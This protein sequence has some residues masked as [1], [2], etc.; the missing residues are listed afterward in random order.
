MKDFVKNLFLGLV[1]VG[2]VGAISHYVYNF[3]GQNRLVGLVF[4]INESTYEH[5]KLMY[6][7][8]IGLIMYMTIKWNDEFMAIESIM[9]IGALA[10]TWTI[11]FLFYTYKG[12]LGREISWIN[13]GTYYLSEIIAGLLI[14]FLT[15]YMGK[16]NFSKI[17]PILIGLYVVQGLMFIWFTYHPLD[18]GIFNEL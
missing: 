10:A 16:K 9:I 12:I 8:M 15:K 18:I 4:P 14:I 7:P 2:I 11:P 1:I 5:M 3:S 6:F 13:V 17:L